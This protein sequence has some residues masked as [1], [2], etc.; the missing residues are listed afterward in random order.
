VNQNQKNEEFKLEEGEFRSDRVTQTT[1]F[2]TNPGINWDTRTVVKKNI[3][4]K[5]IT[6][7]DN[8]SSHQDQEIALKLVDQAPRQLQM[9]QPSSLLRSD[10]KINNRRSDAIK[11]LQSEAQPS[12]FES[13]SH[14]SSS[15]K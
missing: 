8:D 11:V 4:F 1:S 3:I 15:A 13:Q 14:S 6:C 12:S 9:S 7:R 5:K 2:G 10:A